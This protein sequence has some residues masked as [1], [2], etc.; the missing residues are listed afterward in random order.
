MFGYRFETHILS[1]FET[2]TLEELPLRILQYTA[3]FENTF[4]FI[5]LFRRKEKMQ[6][7]LFYFH[8]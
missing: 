6:A 4:N 2:L 3:L 8:S 1:W 7:V 5:T